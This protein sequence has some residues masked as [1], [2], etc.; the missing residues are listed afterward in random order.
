MIIVIM[1]ATDIDWFKEEPSFKIIFF[2]VSVGKTQSRLECQPTKKGPFE[3]PF[4]YYVSKDVDGW[5]SPNADVS[6]RKKK[7][8]KE[9]F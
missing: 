8:C 7:I 1:P 2:G 5:G 6:K 4:K 3:G 9:T